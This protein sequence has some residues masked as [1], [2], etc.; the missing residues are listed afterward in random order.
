MKKYVMATPE[1][2]M[3]N[4]PVLE[5]TEYIKTLSG[6]HPMGLENIDALIAEEYGLVRTI[7]MHYQIKHD[8]KFALFKLKFG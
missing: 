6:P 7:G 5:L 4:M 3:Y 2:K 8:I 1:Y